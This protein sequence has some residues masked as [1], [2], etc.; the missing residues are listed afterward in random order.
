MKPRNIIDENKELSDLFDK[1][2]PLIQNN[3]DEYQAKNGARNYT[4][5]IPWSNTYFESKEYIDILDKIADSSNTNHI[6]NNL[7]LALRNKISQV[8]KISFPSLYDLTLFSIKDNLNR[9]P[10][11]EIN[12]LP[13]SL[14]NDILITK[15]S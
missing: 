1:F 13:R 8:L 7:D 10:D 2:L 14:H 3:L 12:L 6:K 5:L 11:N 9:L 15:L 4:T